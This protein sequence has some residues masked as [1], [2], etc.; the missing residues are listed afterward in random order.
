MSF[1]PV[2]NVAASIMERVDI[3]PLEFFTGGRNSLNPQASAS[4]LYEW[5]GSDVIQLTHD[6][7]TLVPGGN[8][9]GVTHLRAA[10]PDLLFDEPGGI[11]WETDGTLTGTMQITSMGTSAA[12]PGNTDVAGAIPLALHDSTTG[13]DVAPQFAVYSG[14]VDYLKAQYLMP[15]DHAVVI[16]D[17][18]PNSWIKTGSGDDA[19]NG[20]ASGQNVID[21]GGGSN[22]TTGGGGQNTFYLDVRAATTPIWSTITD[23]KPGDAVTVWGFDAGSSWHWDGQMGAQGFQ[24][25]TLEADIHGQTALLTLAGMSQDQAAH[26]HVVGGSVGGSDYLYITA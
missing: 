5:N 9:G 21:A 15:G 10:G 1:D 7:V 20:P 3:G 16:Y 26:L 17:A 12:S 18:T 14:P 6:T 11:T 8:T 13:M 19:I 4:E 24:G 22:F 2:A 23:F 25:A